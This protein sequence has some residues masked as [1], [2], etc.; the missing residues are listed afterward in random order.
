MPKERV[1][2][3]KFFKFC[4]S[5]GSSSDGASGG[6]VTLWNSHF[7][8]GVPLCHDGNHVATLFKHS[9][10]GYSWILSNIYVPNNWISRRKFWAKIFSFQ[11]YHPNISWLVIG[12][13]NTPLQEDE[14][15][16]GSQI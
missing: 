6:V 3:I 11:S 13:F 1:E 10:D 8:Q 12:D 15:F 2:K 9:R 16:G 7:I 4:E 14:K 5:L